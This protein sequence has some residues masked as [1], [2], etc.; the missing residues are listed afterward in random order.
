M[1]TSSSFR[2]AFSKQVRGPSSRSK[3]A[4]KQ[5]RGSHVKCDT[6]QPCAICRRR[7]IECSYGDDVLFTAL[8]WKPSDDAELAVSIPTPRSSTSSVGFRNLELEFVDET[9]EVR[10]LYS[11]LDTDTGTDHDKLP[12]IEEAEEGVLPCPITSATDAFYLARY[13]DVI[14][15][16]F[17]MFDDGGSS[18][19][20]FSSVV[21][22]LALTDRL[23]LLSCLAIAARQQSLVG[24]REDDG[25]GTSAH[26]Q[27]Q[28][29]AYY[30]EAIHL[31]YERLDDE[32]KSQD[33]AVFASCLLIA[34]CEMV[35]SKASDWNLHLKGTG[36]LIAMHNWNG[37]SGGLVQACF[38]I[39]CRMIILASLSAGKPTAIDS[40]EWV[41]GGIFRDPSAWTLEAWQRKVVFLLG[42]MHNFWS[43]TRDDTDAQTTRR[44]AERWKE[45]EAGLLRHQR[46]A[47]AVCF[48][49]SVLPQSDENPFQA[50]RYVNGP[51]AAVWQMLHTALLI[52]TISAPCPRASRLSVLS[53]ANVAEKALSYAR[54]IVANSLAN[55]CLIAWA[56]AVQLLTIAGQ[57]LVDAKER[58]AC[59]TALEQIQWQTGWN[60]RA[61]VERLKA[62]WERK[63]PA[64]SPRGAQQR[65]DVGWLLYTVWLGDE[66][67]LEDSV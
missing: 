31:L 44:R 59:V 33:P 18:Q 24:D 64:A 66:M 63:R 29:L 58:Q 12:T 15:P 7:G 17:D 45:L 10:Q 41:P 67:T 43:Q 52:A 42:E 25:R 13:T 50:V 30:N 39:Y 5:C 22:L 9:S 46:H 37:M 23:V 49:L 2:V 56:N 34:H 8:E 16:R 1:S 38:W 4:C 20:Y 21:P 54:Q 61:N 35:E 28:A 3:L 27:E 40:R 11:V 48:P 6:R 26:E 32:T 57:C 19:R 55:R 51:V 53:S 14:G 47:P 36:N 62:A 60:T 65:P